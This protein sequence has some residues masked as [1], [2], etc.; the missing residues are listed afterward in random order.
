MDQYWDCT[1]ESPWTNA[2]T[3]PCAKP[4][5]ATYFTE[6]AGD[7]SFPYTQ[8]EVG[9][10]PNFQAYTLSYTT[11]DTQGADAVYTTSQTFGL[12]TKFSGSLFGFGFSDTLSLSQT[13]THSYE[14]SSQ[15]TSSNTTTATATIWQPPCNVVDGACSPVYPPSN[16]YNPISCTAISSLNQAFG[17]GYTMY[18][19]QDNLFGTFLMEPYGQ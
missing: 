12:E 11:T 9:A 3:S 2:E 15:F 5:N 1:Y 16:A 14:T 4:P 8:P 17:Q 7:Q 6:S 10:S 18:I 19:Y 13:I